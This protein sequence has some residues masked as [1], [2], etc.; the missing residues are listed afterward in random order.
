MIYDEYSIGWIENFC[1]MLSMIGSSLDV[2][3]LARTKRL[4]SLLK[5]HD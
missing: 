3:D 5:P 1:K 4:A 2:S